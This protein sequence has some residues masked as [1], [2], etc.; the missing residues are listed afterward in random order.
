MAHT[1]VLL[2]QTIDLLDIKSGDI[3]VDATVGNGGHSKAICEHASGLTLI[4]ID[5]D[6]TAIDEASRTLAECSAKKVFV[7]SYY[8]QLKNIIDQNHIS[9]VDK[10]LFDL[11]LRTDQIE[12]A[13]RGF[14]FKSEG[15]LKMTF[16]IDGKGNAVNAY[17]VVNSW[18]EENLADII[19]GFGEETF[20]RRIAK[21]IVEAR[22][23]KPIETTKQLADIVYNAVPFW[24]RHR[25]I[26]PATKTFQAIR[27]A[28]NR[29][30]A[31]I[32]SS[33]NDAFEI[34]N[35]H[36]RVA[37]ITFHSLED[38]LVKRIFH[39]LVEENRAKFINKKPI[40]PEDE[41]I[42]QNPKSRSA[43]LRVIEKI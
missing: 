4:C 36:G 13:D 16:S 12:N 23:E 27:M 20:S 22:D 41:E 18:G 2:K 10:I 29:E 9:K 38:R 14:S 21:A 34:L 11:G 6:Q 1:P 35:S 39:K 32:E 28:V 5:A 31:Q 42:K 30:L 15:P 43:K 26:H 33:V 17:D 40:A 37:V 25:K 24:Y 7:T 3:V 8:D 19:Y